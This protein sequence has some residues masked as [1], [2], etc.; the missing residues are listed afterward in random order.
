MFASDNDHLELLLELG[1]GRGDGGP[2]K[3]RLGHELASPRDLLQGAL[4]Y[5]VS[6]DQ[7]AR[8]RLLV[9][10]GADL[11]TRDEDGHAPAEV[12]AITGNAEIA[13]YLVAYGALPP[14]LESPD[15][16]VGRVSAVVVGRGRRV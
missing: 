1:L 11:G 4:G 3:A 10:H 14:K 8:V 12:A 7:T 15:V 13:E 6:H 2:W 16:S 9:T 5:P